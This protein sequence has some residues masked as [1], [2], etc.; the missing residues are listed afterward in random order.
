MLALTHHVIVRYAANQ[1][2]IANF[3]SYCVLGDDV[4][5]ANDLVAEK[6]LQ[7]MET[8]GVSISL[9]KSIVS[10]RFTEFAKKL[11]G[12]T[13]EF[14]PLGAGLILRASR[15]KFYLQPLLIEMFRLKLFH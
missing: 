6:Y 13:T 14:T 8:L 4:V 9:G 12:P 3:D 5:I 7:I 11:R 1:A 2:G 10:D 15:Y